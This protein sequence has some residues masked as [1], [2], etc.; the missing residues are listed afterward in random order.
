MVV[1]LDC[2]SMSEQNDR[3]SMRQQD[4]LHNNWTAKNYWTAIDQL[5]VSNGI[6]IVFF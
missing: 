6:L 4:K 1:P 2:K 3:S 5:H